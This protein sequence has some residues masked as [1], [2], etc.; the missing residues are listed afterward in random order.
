MAKYRKISSKN[1]QNLNHG[2]YTQRA[3]GDDAT[4]QDSTAS[5]R[6][7]EGGANLLAG[8][9]ALKKRKGVLF[10]RPVKEAPA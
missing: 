4:A 3:G 7:N 8:V 9:P 10:A 5:E 1:D 6:T 2:E